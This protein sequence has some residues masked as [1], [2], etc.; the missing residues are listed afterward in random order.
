MIITK[1]VLTLN[2]NTD[3]MEIQYQLDHDVIKDIIQP[4][5]SL[6]LECD[7]MTKVIHYLLVKNNI[8]HMVVFGSVRFNDRN[9][10]PHFW[11]TLQDGFVI[12]YR[13]RMW[14]GLNAPQ[15]ILKPKKEGV[16]YFGNHISL[17]VNDF[18][19]K[20]LTMEMPNEKRF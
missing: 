9:L 18:E 7:G 2:Q 8:P 15:G 12:D 14:L 3:K 4:Y 16:T 17:Q 20:V 11:I 5:T 6:P 1:I 19:F 13:L 10:S